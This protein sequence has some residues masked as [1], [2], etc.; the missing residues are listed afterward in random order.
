MLTDD[1][2]R[3]L[4]EGVEP[5]LLDIDDLASELLRAREALRD[6]VAAY[7]A[8]MKFC[9]GRCAWDVRDFSVVVHGPQGVGTEEDYFDWIRAL[10]KIKLAG[11]VGEDPRSC[12]P[13]YAEKSEA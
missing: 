8:T 9:L 7:D 11:D 3:G 6:Y 13:E 2:L 12:L 5:I 1:V 10:D 4:S